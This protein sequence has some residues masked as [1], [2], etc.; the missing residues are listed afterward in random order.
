MY[1]SLI[2]LLLVVSLSACS[3]RYNGD[4]T[5]PSSEQKHLEAIGAPA[6]PIAIN[7]VIPWMI[8]KQNETFY[9]SQREGKIIMVNQ[10][11]Q[12][13]EIQDI[14][15]TKEVL[16]Q[17]EG[18]LLGFILAPNFERTQ[19]AFAY[20]TYLDEGKIQNRI[21]LLQKE[22]NTWIEF[23]E[24]LAGIPGAANHNGG[25]MK[26]GPDGMLYVTT[27]D[28]SIPELAQNKNSLAGK[29]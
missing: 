16:H 5:N 15:L 2:C 8:T 11:T 24:L 3:L 23:K 27:G 7:L 25:R 10:E 4:S 18:G 28:A 17:G 22:G 6:E 12:S 13:K 26:I 14:N 1:K 29:F 21:V 19:Q 20:H 9:I